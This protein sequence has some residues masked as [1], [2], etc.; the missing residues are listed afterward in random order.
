MC[1]GKYVV[2]CVPV[3]PAWARVPS[4]LVRQ[5]K[6]ETFESLKHFLGL[7]DINGIPQVTNDPYRRFRCRAS[8]ALLQLLI[9]YV[10]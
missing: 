1:F 10:C 9:Y 8:K 6:L 4:E 3:M 2:V 5:N 7:V